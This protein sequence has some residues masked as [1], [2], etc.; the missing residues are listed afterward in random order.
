VTIIELVGRDRA[1]IAP[2]LVA[3][4]IATLVARTTDDRSV[5]DVR[6]GEAELVERRRLRERLS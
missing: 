4:T 6:L 3:V 5:Y 1:F 2:M